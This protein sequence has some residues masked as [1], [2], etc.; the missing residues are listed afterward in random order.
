M[1]PRK[2]KSKVEAQATTA[3]QRNLLSGDEAWSG[4]TLKGKAAQYGSSYHRT[5]T[6]LL[7][8]IRSALKNS[9]WSADVKSVGRY[10]ERRLVLTSPAGVPHDYV[11]GAAMVLKDKYRK[12]RITSKR[13]KPTVESERTS[14]RAALRR[15][16]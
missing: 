1:I 8:R 14:L 10:R 11:S 2:I 16:T 4:A 3:Y 5:R 7:K 6:A 13:R 9:G 15:D 12:S